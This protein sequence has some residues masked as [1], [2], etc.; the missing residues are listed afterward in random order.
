MAHFTHVR[1]ATIIILII[2]IATIKALVLFWTHG[3]RIA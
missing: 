2:V 3:S 1:G